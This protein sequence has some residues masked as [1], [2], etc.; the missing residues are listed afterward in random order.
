MEED[1]AFVKR[2]VEV[3]FNVEYGITVPLQQHYN[4]HVLVY[5]AMPTCRVFV[6]SEIEPVVAHHPTIRFFPSKNRIGGSL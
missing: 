1:S 4:S 5:P 2:Y 3:H 6:C